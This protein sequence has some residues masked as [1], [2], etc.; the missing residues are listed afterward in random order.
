MLPL[1]YPVLQM[2]CL[3]RCSVV[4]PSGIIPVQIN[5]HYIDA[6]ISGHMGETRDERVRSFVH[7]PRRG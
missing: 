4:M 7:E 2:I 3:L 5:P 6:T 1:R